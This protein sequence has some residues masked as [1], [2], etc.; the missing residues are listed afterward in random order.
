MGPIRIDP[1]VAGCA[2]AKRAIVEISNSSELVCRPRLAGLRLGNLVVQYVN[3]DI[4][5]LIT[6]ALPEAA[7]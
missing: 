6:T 5:M 3:K 4:V 7:Y 2:G 1:R